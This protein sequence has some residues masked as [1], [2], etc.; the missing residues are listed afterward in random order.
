MSASRSEVLAQSKR[1]AALAGVTAAAA[2]GLGAVGWP[3]TA[4]VAGVPA[5]V[6]GYRWWKHRT[7]NGIRF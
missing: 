4:V 5:V 1:K 3:I 6:F 7:E 2:V